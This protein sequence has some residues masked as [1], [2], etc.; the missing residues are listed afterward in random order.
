MSTAKAVEAIL[1][2]EDKAV[3]QII[4]QNKYLFET[5]GVLRNEL[6]AMEKEK[7][8]LEQD[9]ESLSKSKTVLQGYMKN[10]YELNQIE[11]E[12]KQIHQCTLTRFRYFFYVTLLTCILFYLMLIN[13]HNH[14]QYMCY[15]IYTSSLI[16]SFVNTLAFERNYLLNV[17]V[18][19]EQLTKAQKATDLVNDL[20]DNI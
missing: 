8:E 19:N 6:S 2:K 17:K 5:I 12:L 14:M 4:K 11:R 1:N 7:D 18:L 9:V 10:I 16:A 3:D 15:M 13:L 20:F